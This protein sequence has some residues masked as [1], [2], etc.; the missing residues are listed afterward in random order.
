MNKQ[1]LINDITVS[2]T[3]VLGADNIEV[4]KAILSVKLQDYDLVSRKQL[5]STE[6]VDNDEII[7]RFV[8][9]MTA[10]GL[11]MS[12]IKAYLSV[13]KKF[14]ADTN[15][16]IVE[17]TGEHITNYIARM[18]IMPN[19]NG[20]PNSANS[21]RNTYMYLK[22]FFGWAYRKHKI[23]NDIMVD[24]DAVPMPARQKD[25][26]TDDEVE[27]IRENLIN[28]REKALFELMLSTGIRVGEICELQVSDINL[29]ER[30]VF[31]RDGKTASARRTVYLSVKARNAIK[32]YLGAR[33]SGYLFT[34]ING[35]ERNIKASHK[36]IENLAIMMGN[37]ANC[38][39][40]TT[41]HIYRKTFASIAFEKSNDMKLVSQL[42][43]HASTDVTEKCYV[44]DSQE[45]IKNK[46]LRIA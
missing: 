22:L 10:K 7:K 44:V 13:V 16:S 46:A 27:R 43:G 20:K 21:I 9:D 32:K 39:I 1:D 42:L 12:T 33:E 5:P 37:R 26:L 8:I 24:V 30:S 3:T 4:V 28:D 15:L 19:A 6:V 14:F 40:K 23:P 11:K 41:V 36:T 45:T 29:V 25:R 31:I 2:L 38:H 17:V 35:K 18:R 34:T